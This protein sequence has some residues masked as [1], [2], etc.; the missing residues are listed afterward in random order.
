MNF[1]DLAL[2]REARDFTNKNFAQIARKEN[3]Q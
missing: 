3:N 2:K 1:E